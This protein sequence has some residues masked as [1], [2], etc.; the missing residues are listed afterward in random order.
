MF[1]S[2]EEKR[3]ILFRIELLEGKVNDLI[4]KLNSVEPQPTTGKPARQ[5]R[6]WSPEQR[7]AASDR[8]KKKHE[9]EKKAKA[10]A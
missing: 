4:C 3:A 7:A 1:I 2:K 5:G 6:T 10:Q 8:M 9:E